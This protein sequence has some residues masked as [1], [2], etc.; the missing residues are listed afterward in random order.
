MAEQILSAQFNNKKLSDYIDNL[1]NNSKRINKRAK[2]Y[3]K[4]ISPII[5]ADVMKHFNDAPMGVATGTTFIDAFGTPVP[6]GGWS[7]SYRTFM[8]KIGK[9]GNKV[10]QDTGR[11]RQSFKPSK[12]RTSKVGVEWFNNAKTDSGF[13]YAA[14]FDEEAENKE[15]L[16]PFMWL[17]L[18]A[19]ELVQVATL[20]YMLKQRGF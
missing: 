6:W 1:H 17:S 4:S 20:D 3:A 2:D 9:G 13:P 18:K 15:D 14:F 12:F 19:L 8:F 7:D 5:F 10:L 11:L 16:R